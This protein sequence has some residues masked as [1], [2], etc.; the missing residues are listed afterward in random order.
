MNLHIIEKEDEVGRYNIRITD[1]DDMWYLYQ[2]IAPS[3]IA[4]SLTDRKLESRDDQI[5]ADAQPRVKIYLKI[6]VLEIEFHPFTD[7][8]RLKGTII[9]GP[10]D[11]SGHHT[12]NVEPGTNLDIWKSSITEHDVLLLEEAERSSKIPKAIAL[13]IDDESA[14]LFRLRDYGLEPLGK[15]FAG[16]GGKRYPTKDRWQVLVKE[17]IELVSI[18]LS[19]NIPIIVTGPGFLKEIVGKEIRKL[20]DISSNEI[21]I[22]SSSSSGKTGL[23]EAFTR[24]EGIGPL[25]EKL[26]YARE[27]DVIDDLMSRIGKNERVTYGIDQVKRSLTMGA[28][29]KLIL[30]ETLFRTEKGKEL[31]DLSSKTGANHQVISTSHEGGEMLDKIGGAAALLR[32]EI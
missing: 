12:L 27:S 1:R 13:T 32:F 21:Y 24:G 30:T 26:R 3:D 16:P 14:E 31:M 29:E 10:P 22:I 11:I 23:K 19:E 28:V 8:L 6:E 20:K 15:V 4:G 9:E 5:R 18:N 25:L 7:A 2:I 17:A